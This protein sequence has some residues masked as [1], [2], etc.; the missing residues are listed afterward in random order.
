MEEISMD[1]AELNAA[2]NKLKNA[3]GRI[4]ESLKGKRIQLEIGK[5]DCSSIVSYQDTVAKLK[6]VLTSYCQLLEKDY[7]NLKSVK[8]TMELVDLNMIEDVTQ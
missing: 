3:C 6:E 5:S 4:E 1:K 7:E 8:K 2:I